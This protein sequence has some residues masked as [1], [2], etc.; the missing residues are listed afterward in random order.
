MVGSFVPAA[1]GA[2]SGAGPVAGCASPAAGGAGVAAPGAVA[3]CPSPVA[4]GEGSGTT[5]VGAGL[6]G[7]EGDCGAGVGAVC[8]NA[9]AQSDE[10][11]KEVE[12]S[13][14]GR[15]FTKS[16]HRGQ[17]ERQYLCA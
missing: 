4:G 15:N 3:G 1:S 14:R 16:P 10:T 17:N 12:A 11:K 2:C 7:A 5:G 8:A 9:P 6:T 13:N